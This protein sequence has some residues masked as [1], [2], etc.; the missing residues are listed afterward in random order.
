MKRKKPKS[1]KMPQPS[2]EEMREGIGVVFQ[3]LEHMLHAN[4]RFIKEEIRG[5]DFNEVVERQDNARTLSFLLE[6]T[7]IVGRH[8]S[9][10]GPAHNDQSKV[11]AWD[12][13]RATR[14]EFEHQ[15]EKHKAFNGSMIIP[16]DKWL[17]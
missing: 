7:I 15:R 12:A 11:P 17:G 8:F 4:E 14:K 1:F 2:P 13:L 16:E 9:G 10:L 5:K 6:Q 3:I